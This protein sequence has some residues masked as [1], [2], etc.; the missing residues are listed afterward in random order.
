[1]L[2]ALVVPG[3]EPHRPEAAPAQVLIEQA[4]ER[5]LAAPPLPRHRDGERRL[6]LA[7]TEEPGD[8]TRDGAEVQRVALAGPERPVRGEEIGDRDCAALDR[9][10]APRP[11]RANQAEQQG[12]AREGEEQR[13]G[14]AAVLD[15]PPRLAPVGRDEHRASPT[16]RNRPLGVREGD[17]LKQCLGA[18]RLRL[19]VLTPV[20]REEHRASATY[21]KR[22]LGV[23]E[24]D[25]RKPCR[26]AALGAREG[27]RRKPCLGATRLR[28]P[29]LAPVGRDE[30]RASLT[31]RHRPLGVRE[32][33]RIK[34]CLGATRLRSPSAR[35]H[36]SK[37]APCLCDLLQTP[38][39][40]SRRRPIQAMP[41]CRS[42]SAA[43]SR[44][45]RSRGAPCLCYPP[46][47]PARRSRRRP[48]TSNSSVPLVF[49]CQALAPVGRE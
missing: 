47:P 38:A 35:P 41:R 8:P 16:Y 27:D 6:G 49:G 21:R 9:H 26:G 4:H 28:L 32:G 22:P 3:V 40:R 17:R 34:Q 36:R 25:R 11:P 24:G 31:Y 10:L 14:I 7:V 1:M 29:A 45:R 37:R 30:H 46:P 44:P 15:R 13:R 23:R 20:G 2:A 33:D 42:P 43:S 18:T 48:T 12:R 19:P 39:R 5:A